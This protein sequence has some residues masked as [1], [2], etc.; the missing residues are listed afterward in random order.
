MN[1]EILVEIIREASKLGR[2][3]SGKELEEKPLKLKAS[4]I[5]EIIDELKMDEKTKD[6]DMIRGKVEVYF[7]SKDYISNTYRDVLY[8]L[9]EKNIE[10]TI[11]ELVR[12]ESKLYPRPTS[13]ETFKL[14]PF[15]RKD[16]DYLLE[17]ILTTKEYTD[18]KSVEASN[19][20]RYLFS[21]IYMVLGHAKGLCEWVE[22]GQFENP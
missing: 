1:K 15:N 11:V 18:I 20:A 4:K 7:Y 8:N 13:L 19:G 10:E 9:K 12:M 2:L 21:D 16:I 6:I 3:I 14:N 5:E 22:V 17:K